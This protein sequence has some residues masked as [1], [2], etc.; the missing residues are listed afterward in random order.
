MARPKTGNR[1]LYTEPTMTTHLD[2]PDY[3]R[4]EPSVAAR[5]ERIR[6]RPVV[7]NVSDLKK[8]FGTPQ[9]EHVVF[10][11]VSFSYAEGKEVLHGISFQAQPGTVTAF[12]GP[13][14][15]GKST[16]IGLIAAFHKPS[17][18]TVLVEG[19]L[20]ALAAA[21]RSRRGLSMEVSEIALRPRVRSG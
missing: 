3:R 21:R 20:A 17:A 8:S 14:G 18:G 13:S 7:L 19:L 9:R 4:Q 5:F 16:T 12:V 15:S 1:R 6:Q 2:L 10:D 11:R